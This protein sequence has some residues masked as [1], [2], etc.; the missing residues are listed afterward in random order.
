MRKQPLSLKRSVFIRL[1][2]ITVAAVLLFYAIGLYINF[3]GTENVREDLQ[4][5]MDTEVQYIAGEIEREIANLLVF[6]QELASDN[7]LL[8]YVIA[9]DILSD[10]QRVEYVGSISDQLLRITRFSPV[11][12][13]AKVYLPL[14]GVTI[15]ADRPIYD[16]LVPG[17]WE[18]VP[19]MDEQRVWNIFEWDNQIALMYAKYDRDQPLFIIEV[20][21][22]TEK[23]IQRLSIMR[24]NDRVATVLLRQDRTMLAVDAQGDAIAAE[25]V[26]TEGDSPEYM[27]SEAEIPT[28]GLTLRCINTTSAALQPLLRHRV[29]VWVLTLLAAVLLVAYL[30]YYQAYILRPLNTIFES[31]R[32]AEKTGHF[33]I[34]Q[35]NADFDDIYAQFNSMVARIEELA[36]QVYEEQ[37]RAQQAELRQLQMQINPHFFYNTLFM[38]YR[39]AQKEGNDEIAR[40]SLNLSNYY[41]YIT[42]MPEHDVA[43]AHEVAHV[44]QYLDIQRVRF[45]PRVTIEMQ[46]L[47]AALEEEK[48]PPLI[49]QPIVENAFIHGMKDKTRDGYV[50]VSFD[51]DDRWYAITVHDNGGHMDEAAVKELNRRLANGEM[52]D[53]SALHNLNRRLILRYGA[54]YTLR[55]ESRDNGLWV[56]I[57][58][59]RREA[60]AHAVAADR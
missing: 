15:A 47:P 5:A 43:L 20:G 21:L 10:Y 45:S 49:L 52:E 54:N 27:I 9:Y 19:S 30:T 22:S 40:L 41:R 2:G 48:L 59:P 60:N 55:L 7:H 28:L 29:W 13:T 58:L 50:G 3:M 31:V 14:R 39:M 42:Q 44:R 56:S 11:V 46:E 1:L 32:K 26:L 35:R 24:G 4:S 33:L 34:D 8:R 36:S 38:V 18:L 57:R 16:N 12:E 51:Y 25:G 23:L 53:G 6:Q 37:Y 17:A